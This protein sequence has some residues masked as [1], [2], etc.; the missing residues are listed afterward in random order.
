MLEGTVFWP[1]FYSYCHSALFASV[2][3]SG[4]IAYYCKR[5]AVLRVCVSLQSCVIFATLWT[6]ACQAPLSR[7]EYLSVLPC[8]SPED[9]PSPGIE[10][11]SLTSTCIGRWVHYCYCHLGSPFLLLLSIICLDLHL[12]HGEGNG[13]HSSTLAWK[14]P[15]TEEPGRLQSMGSRRVGHD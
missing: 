8:C 5:R 11:A 14:I 13:T 12:R 9:L 7:Q 4:K 6:V 1:S 15:W 3:A 2:N 10:P